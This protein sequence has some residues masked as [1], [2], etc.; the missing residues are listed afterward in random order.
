MRERGKAVG[1]GERGLG[2][3]L[4]D[5]GCVSL[6]R[7][8]FSIC[9]WCCILDCLPSVCVELSPYPVICVRCVSVLLN[10]LISSRLCA[11]SYPHFP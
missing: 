3:G 5:W 10:Y 7:L 11:S 9:D 6:P 2:G 1:G 8:V 4:F